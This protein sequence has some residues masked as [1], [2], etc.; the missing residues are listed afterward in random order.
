MAAGS[1]TER[2][3]TSP[4]GPIRSRRERVIQTLWFEALI[5]ALT[6]LGWGRA[7]LADVALTAAYAVHGYVF[8]LCF[9]RLRPVK[10]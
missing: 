4:P 9:D 1:V 2:T 3:W 5:V 10:R 7:L 6:P 8:H